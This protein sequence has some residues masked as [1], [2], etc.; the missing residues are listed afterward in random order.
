MLRVPAVFAFAGVSYA[1]HPIHDPNEATFLPYIGGYHAFAL[2]LSVLNL[3][4][5]VNGLPLNHRLARVDVKERLADTV[6]CG[7]SRNEPDLFL[8]LAESQAS[9]L[10]FPQISTPKEVVD[11]YRSGDGT[12]KSLYVETVGG[13]TWMTNFSVLTGLST[14]DL[15]W[16]AAYVTSLLED[17]VKGAL[18]ELLARCGYRTVSISPMEYMAMHEGPFLKSIGFQEIYAAEALGIKPMTVRDK[19]YYAFAER[20]IEEHRHTDGR[21]L[22]L[23]MQT[24]YSHAP[25]DNVLLPSPS[26]PQHAYSDRPDTNEYMRR[27]AI[28]RTDLQAFQEKR[29]TTPGPNGSV[30]AEFGDHQSVATRDMMLAS[31]P[32]KPILTDFRSPIYETYFAVRAYD[33]EVDYSLLRQPEDAAFLG[34]RLIA[35]AQLPTSP[36]YDDLLEQSERCAGR[37]HTCAERGGLDR[38]L[39]ARIDAGMLVLR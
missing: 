12:I 3:P 6:N 7:S 29:K 35:A 26:D 18:P 31:H 15:D 2:P 28:A 19:D 34:A 23:H 21:P 1:A 37:F 5:L 4:D 39:K 22:F 11:S 24:M 8:I 32:G 36:L 10:I 17:K 38:N 13:G 20:L 16:Q 30:V 33:T 9:P 27:V 25:Y 14:A